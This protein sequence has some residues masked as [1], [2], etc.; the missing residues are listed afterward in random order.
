MPSVCALSKSAI[1]RS[2]KKKAKKI[3][4]IVQICQLCGFEYH[5]KFDN[6]EK[7]EEVAMKLQTS[8][9]S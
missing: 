2:Q 5:R 1:R 7:A 6:A 3:V 8:G 4:S 9:R